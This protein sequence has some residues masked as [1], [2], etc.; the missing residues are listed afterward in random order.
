MKSL[1]LSLVFLFLTT[2]LR[3]QNDRAVF[4]R[5]IDYIN[6]KLV[7]LSL[8]EYDPDLHRVFKKTKDYSL[9]NEAAYANIEEVRGFLEQRQLRATIELM[10]AIEDAK[11]SYQTGW[12]REDIQLYLDTLIYESDARIQAFVDKHKFKFENLKAAIDNEVGRYLDAKWP[13]RNVL[14]IRPTAEAGGQNDAKTGKTGFELWQIFLLIALLLL[15]VYLI[16][17]FRR[18]Q[19]DGSL[20]RNKYDDDSISPP[21]S[22]HERIGLSGGAKP[23]LKQIKKNISEKEQK[24]NSQSKREKTTPPEPRPEVDQLN[25]EIKHLRSVNKRLEKEN[26]EL[27]EKNAT[28]LKELNKEAVKPGGKSLQKARSTIVRQKESAR[29]E[30]PPPTAA[31]SEVFYLSMPNE[32]GSFDDAPSPFREMESLYKFTVDRDKGVGTFVFAGD[33]QII[34]NVVNRPE[35]YLVAVCKNLNPINPNARK[36]VTEKPGEV[37]L[38]DHKWK[39]VEK[40][41]IRFE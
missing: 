27:R 26:Q 22:W 32:D 34:K 13:R 12:R 9:E 24:E 23:K 33:S 21:K 16:L 2:F 30:T 17:R 28:L 8:E 41:Q 36:I 11:R 25:W 4:D 40:A 15:V 3:G 7:E 6:Y 5:A 29:A 1:Y 38:E 20:E 18:K 14:E 37:M 19:I 39:L 35:R 10:D 31:P